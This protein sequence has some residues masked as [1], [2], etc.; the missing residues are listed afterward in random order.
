MA[1][2][3]KPVMIIPKEK[4]VFMPVGTEAEEQITFF[5]VDGRVAHFINDHKIRLSIGVKYILFRN[6][7]CPPG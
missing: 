7:L 5:T 1:Y 3:Q 2:E 6:A 4:A